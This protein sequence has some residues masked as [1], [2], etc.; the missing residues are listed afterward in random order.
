MPAHPPH[1]DR[2][3]PGNARLRRAGGTGEPQKR[4]HPRPMQALPLS[5]YPLFV[6]EWI[7][8]VRSP[9]RHHAEAQDLRLRSARRTVQCERSSGGSGPSALGPSEAV[10]VDPSGL[11][12]YQPRRLRQDDLKGMN[13]S[14]DLPVDTRVGR[15]VRAQRQAQGHRR[16]T[17][18]EELEGD[19]YSQQRN[20]VNHDSDL[21]IM[22][23]SSARV[24]AHLVRR[25]RSVC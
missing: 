1:L 10:R 3:W 24:I 5:F 9:S 18:G 22:K 11:S 6:P 13:R 7:T 25:T 4:L 2:Q 15:E 8:V 12:S 21:A 14:Q 16:R 23:Q 17:R 20:S 19:G